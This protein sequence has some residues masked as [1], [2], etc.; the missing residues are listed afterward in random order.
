MRPTCTSVAKEQDAATSGVSSSHVLSYND[1]HGNKQPTIQSAR[2][3]AWRCCFMK[4]CSPC[5]HS[6]RFSAT[7]DC[8]TGSAVLG[9][10]GCRGHGMERTGGRE[11]FTWCYML[12][13]ELTATTSSGSGLPS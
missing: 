2:T 12:S 13:E 8:R 1:H 9:L 3:L 4:S 10:G 5:R 7:C 11:G 6:L